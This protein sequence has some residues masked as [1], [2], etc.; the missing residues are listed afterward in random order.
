ML[1]KAKKYAKKYGKDLDDVLLEIA[2]DPNGK[3]K[4]KLAAIKVF[5]DFTMA[6]ISEGGEADKS[7]GP[8]V[9]LPT[10]HPRGPTL[11]AVDGEKVA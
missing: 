1:S 7:L 11:A 6:K 10:Q 3:A 9:F 4:D 5:K 8:A 2:L